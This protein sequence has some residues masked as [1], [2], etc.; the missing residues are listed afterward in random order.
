MAYSE[1]KTGNGGAEVAVAAIGNS[2]LL[3]HS[4][5]LKASAANSDIGYVGGSGVTILTG[6][7]LSAGNELILFIDDP[8]K[9]Y[10]I[11]NPSQN[12]KQ[13]ITY[14]S[15]AA[16]EEFKLSFGITAAILSKTSVNMTFKMV[17]WNERLFIFTSQLFS[18]ANPYL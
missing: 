2:Q 16:N 11:A 8:A 7:E 10:V 14:N 12:E 3:N 6:Y 15:G 18:F 9:V 13:T 1:F 5:N 17:N 4:V